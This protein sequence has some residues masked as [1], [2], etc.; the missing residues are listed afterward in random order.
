[1]AA[2]FDVH[3]LTKDNTRELT[4]VA[5]RS[6][7]ALVAV[8][9]RSKDSP[10]IWERHSAADNVQIFTGEAKTPSKLA[11]LLYMCAH[12]QVHAPLASVMATLLYLSLH[13][14]FR[15]YVEDTVVI[16]RH[17]LFDIQKPGIAHPYLATS[18]NW[19]SIRSSS[20]LMQNRDFVYVQHQDELE[21]PQKGW[22]SCMHSVNLPSCPPLTDRHS[23]VRGGIYSS[24]FV[25]RES[26]RPG[27][28]DAVFVLQVDFKGKVPRILCTSTLKHWVSSLGRLAAYFDRPKHLLRPSFGDDDEPRRRTDVCRVC[29][30]AFGGFRTEKETCRK[31]Q[32]QICG[33]CAMWSE[34]EL[35]VVGIIKVLVCTPCAVKEQ[36]RL[37]AVLAR[38]VGSP[39]Y[40]ATIDSS[41]SSVGPTTTCRNEAGKTRSLSLYDDSSVST[42]GGMIPLQFSAARQSFVEVPE[43]RRVSLPARMA[44]RPSLVELNAPQAKAA[45]PPRFVL[46]RPASERSVA[47]A[48]RPHFQRASISLPVAEP[49]DSTRCV[50]DDPEFAWRPRESVSS[51]GA[52][53]GDMDDVL[54]D[55]PSMVQLYTLRGSRI[56]AVVGDPV[57]SC[58]L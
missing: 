38:L 44:S 36:H 13:G 1:M 34:V 3:G 7:D 56:D 5:R 9:L 35:D 28:L 15:R 39:H 4:A 25:F 41:T 17:T 33:K 2:H 27:V 20:P 11:P 45:L 43:G 58:I 49:T 32:V 57:R 52:L 54:S 42:V 37:Q 30:Q 21:G 8:A 46:G 53:A 23:L 18:I 47:A 40:H 22:I 6:A 48:K 50:Y 16:N 55:T 29:D 12:T 24:G 10:V 14:D 19:M 31:C 26:T 51:T